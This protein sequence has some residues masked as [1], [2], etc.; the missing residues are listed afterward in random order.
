MYKIHIWVL[1][2]NTYLFYLFGEW[3]VVKFFQC[4]LEAL[5]RPPSVTKASYF[6]GE[7][8]YLHLWWL[9]SPSAAVDP[10]P[11]HTPNNTKSC[12]GVGAGGRSHST[13]TGTKASHI[14]RTVEPQRVLRRVPR[15]NTR[16][17]RRPERG[18][19][20]LL[21]RRELSVGCL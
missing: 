3:I 4:R 19:E 13:P 15:W 11:A 20:Y 5:K 9:M 6:R 2:L 1:M 12:S 10:S 18:V 21:S 7:L 8:L 16:E 14:S 17:R